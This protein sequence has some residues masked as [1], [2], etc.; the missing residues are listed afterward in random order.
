VLFSIPV[1]GY[2]HASD[3]GFAGFTAPP[4][5][6]QAALWQISPTVTNWIIV[7][8]GLIFVFVVMPAIWSR[9]PARRAAA[10]AVLDRL[11]K[12]FRR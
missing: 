2:K 12:A 4:G 6:H 7:A 5:S 1:I 9:D 11:L 10:L 8:A 3:V